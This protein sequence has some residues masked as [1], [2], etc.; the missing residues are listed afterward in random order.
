MANL[1]ELRIA[2]MQNRNPRPSLIAD[3]FNYLRISPTYELARKFRLGLLSKAQIKEL[4]HDFESA[5]KTYDDFGDVW[6]TNH[7]NW[8]SKKWRDLFEANI[9]SPKIRTLAHL[10]EGEHE[11][12]KIIENN[13]KKYLEV[14]RPSTGYP[15]TFIFAIPANT[16]KKRILDE[17]NLALDQ[18][19][20]SK[21]KNQNPKLVPKPKYACLI[22]KV[23]SSALRTN[24]QIVM[25]KALHPKWTLWEIAI[26]LKLN[27]TYTEKIEEAVAYKDKMKQKGGR[28]D[29]AHRATDEKQ[30]INAVMGRYI[31]N[32]FLL[33]E[34]AARGQF[35]C[36]DEIYDAKANKVK[37]NFDYASISI[38]F[39]ENAKLTK[40][41]REELE[42][43]D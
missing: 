24:H 4:P 38:N 16:T 32:A 12:S 20:K 31:R 30:F 17:V 34:N 10:L 8:A 33:S 15:A 36:L 37:T 13:L 27:R 11:E 40:K 3:W 5:L 21:S 28:V 41:L 23:R 6:A 9:S 42:S 18:Y 19:K 26:D 1:K 25:R 2:P 14:E 43:M 39:A 35:P 7:P 29:I 22:T